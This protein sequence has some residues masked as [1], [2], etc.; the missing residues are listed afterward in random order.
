[1]YFV[2]RMARRHAAFDHFLLASDFSPAPLFPLRSLELPPWPIWPPLRPVDPRSGHHD[3]AVV[4]DLRV[5]V[6]CSLKVHGFLIGG[7]P[8]AAVMQVEFGPHLPLRGGYIQGQVSA[9]FG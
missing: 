1:M 9:T 2:Y 4:V 5:G 7:K 3:T 8:D 6:D